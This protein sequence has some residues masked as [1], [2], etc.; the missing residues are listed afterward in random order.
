MGGEIVFKT[1]WSTPQNGSWGP[2]HPSP[3][4]RVSL[5]HSQPALREC[6]PCARAQPPARRKEGSWDDMHVTLEWARCPST[7]SAPVRL[8]CTL[9]VLSSQKFLSHSLAVCF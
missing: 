2:L 5:G 9:G 6:T 4:L 8:T 7:Q 3:L 1:L